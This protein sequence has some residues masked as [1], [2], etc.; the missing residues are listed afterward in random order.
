[1]K[2]RMQVAALAAASLTVALGFSTA[3]TSVSSASLDFDV[4]IVESAGP[5]SVRVGEQV[6]QI[7]PDEETVPA[8]PTARVEID[9]E[10]PLPQATPATTPAPQPSA[11]VAVPVGPPVYLTF[12]DGPDPVITP[13][14][15]DL[16][17]AHNAKATFF[18]QGSQVEAYPDLARRIVS[19]GHSLQNHAW[20]HPRLPNLT[21]DEI[22]FGQLQPTNEAITAATGVTP[23]CLRAPY[24]ATSPTVFSAA[25]AVGLEVV[26][27]NLDP[28]D[29]NNPGASA[30]SGFVLNNI[31]PGSIVLLHDAGSGDRQQ[32]VDALATLLP[33]LSARGLAPTALCQ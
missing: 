22:T 10:G 24:G 23:S 30:I 25:A 27:W 19:E 18:V 33:E 28:G 12:D 2:P 8:E 21:H 6:E 5:E 26:G 32:T 7:V 9:G 11:E 15:L 29:Y 16:L 4:P 14:V 17:A 20:N 13:Q 1:M 3:V 31:S